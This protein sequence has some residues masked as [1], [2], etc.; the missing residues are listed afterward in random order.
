[1]IY[2][3]IIYD[4]LYIKRTSAVGKSVSELIETKCTG[5]MLKEYHMLSAPSEVAAGITQ[6]I[7][8]K[9]A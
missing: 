6:A 8:Q 1:M 2:I 9:S 4:D 3:L 5:P 7:C